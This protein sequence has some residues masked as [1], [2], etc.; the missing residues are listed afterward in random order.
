MIADGDDVICPKYG[1][2]ENKAVS[3]F[4]GF[5]GSGTVKRVCNKCKKEY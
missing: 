1:S 2:T 4:T 5:L 3:V